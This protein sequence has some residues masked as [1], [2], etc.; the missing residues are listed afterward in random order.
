MRS[1]LS[2][3]TCLGICFAIVNA[4]S[5]QEPA[6]DKWTVRNNLK[7]RFTI[8]WWPVS[9]TRNVRSKSINPDEKFTLELGPDSHKVELRSKGGNVYKFKPV[10]LRGRESNMDDILT[11]NGK[12]DGVRQYKYM[13]QDG[14]FKP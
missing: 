13:N 6:M 8:T 7:E 2:I 3:T 12:R 5:S 4:S 14:F 11:P 9:E 10:K 1:Y